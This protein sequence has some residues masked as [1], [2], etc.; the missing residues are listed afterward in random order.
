MK[1]LLTAVTVAA[2]AATLVASTAT[3]VAAQ[4]ASASVPAAPAGID[5]GPCP[6]PPAG[7]VLNPQQTCGT[8]R[9]PLDYRRPAGRQITIAVSRVP[10]T[11]PAHRRGVLLLN[12]GGPGGEGLDLPSG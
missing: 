7:V 4:P 9:V 6:E 8:I 12:P 11:D 1:K 5:W 10:A 2:L 3:L